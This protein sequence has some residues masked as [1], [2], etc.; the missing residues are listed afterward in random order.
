MK[1][2]TNNSKIA[3][4]SNFVYNKYLIN[5]YL[6]YESRLFYT[7]YGQDETLK[8]SKMKLILGLLRNKLKGT[9]VFYKNV[10]KLI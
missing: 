8:L 4:I 6:V 10:L 2:L 3:L 5:P 9:F 1:L 7:I